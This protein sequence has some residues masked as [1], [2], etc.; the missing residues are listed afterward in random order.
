L[1][2]FIGDK[3]KPCG[4]V[5]VWFVMKKAGRFAVRGEKAACDEEGSRAACFF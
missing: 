5:Q 4:H 2:P 3:K 1:L